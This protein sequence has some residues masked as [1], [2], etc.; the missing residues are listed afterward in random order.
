LA[1]CLPLRAASPEA[2]P[3][4]DKSAG[5]KAATEMGEALKRD[6]VLQPQDRIRIDIFQEPE[7]SKEVRVLQE[8][9]VTLPLVGTIELTGKSVR[10]AEE[11]IRELYEKDFLVDPQVAVTVVE[12]TARFVKV[13]GS[14]GRPGVVEFPPEK[15]LTLL[16]AIARAGAFNRLADKKRVTLTRTGPDGKT[17]TSSHDADELTNPKRGAGQDVPLM[18]DDVIFVGERIL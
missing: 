9:T 2:T 13:F 10:Q 3:D 15:G 1:I 5:E 7:L 11:F 4:V 6:Y 12:Y 16:E 14:V 18:P 17:E 8:G